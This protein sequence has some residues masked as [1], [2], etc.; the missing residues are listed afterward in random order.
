M[1]LQNYKKVCISAKNRDKKAQLNYFF[2]IF[3]KNILPL[4]SKI[5]IR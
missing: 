4:S 2:C 1:C 3:M 5:C